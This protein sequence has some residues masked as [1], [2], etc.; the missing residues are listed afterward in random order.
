MADMQFLHV[1]D[2]IFTVKNGVHSKTKTAK[3]IPRTLEAFFSLLAIRL[4]I[5]VFTWPF[6]L[7]RRFHFAGIAT[8]PETFPMVMALSVSRQDIGGLSV[9]CGGHG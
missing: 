1:T 2:R 5:I 9:V 4:D 8:L 6:C 3:I 7:R